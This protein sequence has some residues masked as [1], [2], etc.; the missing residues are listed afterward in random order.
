M[1]FAMDADAS[2]DQFKRAHFLAVG[3]QERDLHSG[4]LSGTAK[5]H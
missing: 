4:V 1:V 5:G 3:I 2:V